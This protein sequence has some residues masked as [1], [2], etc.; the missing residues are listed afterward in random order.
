MPETHMCCQT[1][2][3]AVTACLCCLV[4]FI[5]S[6]QAQIPGDTIAY[7]EFRFTLLDVQK[8]ELTPSTITVRI[9]DI[10]LTDSSN[11]SMQYVTAKVE[12][13]E[14]DSCWILSQYDPLGYQ[15]EL[16]VFRN[17]D[18]V[19]LRLLELRKMTILWP[20]YHMVT[21]EGCQYCICNDI[22]FQKG[23]YT[24]DVPKRPESWAFI[25]KLYINIRSLPIEFRDISAIQNWMLN[26]G[27]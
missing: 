23:V 17:S 20:G 21:Q 5:S 13:S 11:G 10:F 3:N 1:Q 2:R 24:I 25:R 12:Y 15:Y 7:S 6:M 26:S 18:T 22:P 14:K 9:G 4:G 19:N 27:K 8:K 16:E